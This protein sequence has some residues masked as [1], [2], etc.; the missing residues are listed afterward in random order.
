MRLWHIDLIPYLPKS[1]LVAQWRE[2][3]SIFKK[4]DK[5][6]LINYIYDYTKFYIKDYTIK[7]MQEM[8]NRK[9]KIRSYENYNDYFIEDNITG[10]HNLR[11]KEHNKEYLTICYYNLKE[12]YLRG[13][14]D[15]TDDVWKRLNEFYCKTMKEK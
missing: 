3:N 13:Q 11:F 2:L 5:H 14:K 6:I 10:N 12:K 15:F 7:V 8:F 9:I 1:Q 4:Q